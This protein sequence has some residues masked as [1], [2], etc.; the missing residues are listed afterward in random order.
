LRV[1]FG[2]GDAF[3]LPMAMAAGP[4]WHSLLYFIEF[5]FFLPFR[6]RIVRTTMDLIFLLFFYK[7]VTWESTAE[8]RKSSSDLDDPPT[9]PLTAD[10]A[11]AVGRALCAGIRGRE[12]C[13]PFLGFSTLQ[14]TNYYISQ[15]ESDI[16]AFSLPSLEAKQN[17]NKTLNY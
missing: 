12:I 6:T 14:S 1:G 8:Q 15:S 11:A 4:A 10:V 2:R 7:G 17:P 5:S 16:V 9:N 3:G 13:R